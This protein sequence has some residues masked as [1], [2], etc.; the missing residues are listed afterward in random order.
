MNTS[1]QGKAQNGGLFGQ[2]NRSGVHFHHQITYTG[3]PKQW[4]ISIKKDGI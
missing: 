2:H 4:L 3:R 1:L